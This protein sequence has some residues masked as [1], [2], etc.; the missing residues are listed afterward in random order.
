MSS[1]RNN[2]LL[3]PHHSYCR[4]KNI[5]LKK[6]TG[7]ASENTPQLLNPFQ[8]VRHGKVVVWILKGEEQWAETGIAF[9]WVQYRINHIVQLKII[10]H[11]H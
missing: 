1:K 8:G 3:T 11:P 7:N 2:A 10:T 5:Y 9:H 4:G 6:G